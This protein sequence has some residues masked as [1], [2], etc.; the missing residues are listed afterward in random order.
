MENPP[1]KY[2]R[3]SPGG[4]VRLKGA[5]ILNAMRVI[6]DNAGC[7]VQLNCS[8]IPESKSGNDTSGIKSKGHFALGK[9]RTCHNR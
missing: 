5:Y 2:F 7:I 8:Y 1:K 3:L 4:M 9:R 6:K